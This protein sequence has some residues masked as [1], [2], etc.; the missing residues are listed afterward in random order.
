MQCPGTEVGTCTF[1][2]MTDFYPI[3]QT[4]E[5]GPREVKAGCLRSH[6]L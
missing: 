2:Y 6:I 5:Q 4:K 3:S 1:L